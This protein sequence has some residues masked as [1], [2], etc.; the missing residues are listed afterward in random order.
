MAWSWRRAAM[1]ANDRYSPE[2]Y[3]SCMFAAARAQVEA[4]ARVAGG[5]AA[6]AA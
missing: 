1:T 2:A 4:V 6:V 3:T 5:L